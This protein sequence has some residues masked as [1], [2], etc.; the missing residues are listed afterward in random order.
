M[1]ETNIWL[2]APP[3]RER[4]QTQRKANSLGTRR[5]AATVDGHY[6]IL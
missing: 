5:M 6:L 2:Q 3:I 4:L 1:L